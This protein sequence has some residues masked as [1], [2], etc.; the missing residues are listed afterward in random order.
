MFGKFQGG[1][2]TS[3][4]IVALPGK[5]VLTPL[6]PEFKQFSRR[7]WMW[8]LSRKCWGTHAFKMAENGG[9]SK[10]SLRLIQIYLASGSAGS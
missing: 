9:E 3:D 7:Q 8:T 2:L 6:L 10:K 1:G 5:K 4:E